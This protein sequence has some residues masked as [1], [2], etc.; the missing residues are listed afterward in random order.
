[1]FFLVFEEIYYVP[2]QRLPRN[3]KIKPR[4]QG[5]GFFQPAGKMWY[6]LQQ[7]EYAIT[8]E[9]S[10]YKYAFMLLSFL[11]ETTLSHTRLTSRTQ[12][13]FVVGTVRWF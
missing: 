6:N 13:Y 4:V 12:T 9:T 10:Y 11:F 3:T 5:S 1:M 8:A 7:K 2:S